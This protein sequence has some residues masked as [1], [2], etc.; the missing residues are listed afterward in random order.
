MSAAGVAVSPN[1][2]LLRGHHG[3]ITLLFASNIQALLDTFHAGI[4]FAGIRAN[5][6]LQAHQNDRAI[7][8]GG[9]D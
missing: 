2:I 3:G 9:H 6:P 1:L 5:L 8:C 7:S 4:L